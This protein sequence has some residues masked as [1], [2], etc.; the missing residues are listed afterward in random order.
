MSLSSNALNPALIIARKRDG[1]T[2]TNSEIGAFVKGYSNGSIPDYQASAFCMAICLRGMNTAET[3][4]LTEHMLHSGVALQWANAM[5]PVVDK[6]STGGVGDKVS[7][8]LAPLL[9]S[10]GLYVPMISGRGLGPTG[11]TLDK[12]ESIPGFRTDLTARQLQ[13]QTQQLGCAISGATHEIAPADQK[14]YALR[15]VTGTVPS[16]A[17]ITASILSKK[18][19]EGLSALV[20]DVKCGSGALMKTE[21]AAVELAESLVTTS[22]AMGVATTA[23]VTSMNQPLGAAV[24]NAIEVE[25]ALATLRGAGPSDLRALTLTLATELMLLTAQAG[26][27]HQAKTALQDALDSGAALNKFTEMVTAQGGDL[28]HLPS[29]QKKTDVNALTAGFITRIDTEALALTVIALGGGRRLPTDTINHQV[30]LKILHKVSDHVEPG[31]PLLEIFA[32]SVTTDICKQLRTAITIEA[33]QPEPPPLI[34]QTL[35]SP[36][37]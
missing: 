30:G 15:D 28:A 24:G 14:L 18:L 29:P 26:T 32:P 4:A 34:Y 6:H 21:R 35:R 33:C 31:T 27:E 25:E 7:L 10:V 36:A 5:R 20:L 2:L 23:F 13:E 22:A 16:R 17:L 37:Q 19:A 8:V 9:A 12:L 3:T 1:E 11:G